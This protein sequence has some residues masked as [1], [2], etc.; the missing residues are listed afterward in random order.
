MPKILV[1]DDDANF[2]KLVSVSLDAAGYEVVAAGRIRDA[3]TRLATLKP[4]TI[5]VDGLLPDGD[6]AAWIAKRR[7]ALGVPVIFA[8][9]FW[10]GTRESRELNANAKPDGFLR[11]PATPEQ[12]L[13][14]VERVLCVSLP[15]A[16]LASAP[17]SFEALSAE[18]AAG[19]PERLA[20][21]RK[22]LATVEK[23]PR[24]TVLFAEVR[25]EAHEL[26]GT[27]GSFGFDELTA[28]GNELEL[29]L[30]KWQKSAVAAAWTPIARAISKLEW[31]LA[32]LPAAA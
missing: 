3:E 28:I 12:I 5:L 19:L 7:K 23:R 16:S 25:R 10:K 22:G 26:A 8:S 4:D 6:G 20:Q 15:A 9:A 2:R 1:I 13:A 27:A 24:D 11:K 29:A 21:L 31:W 14:E 32:C 30:M 17:E 18:Y